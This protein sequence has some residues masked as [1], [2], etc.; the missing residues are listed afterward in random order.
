MQRRSEFAILC[1]NPPFYD[2]KRFSQKGFPHGGIS[3][4]F[5][6][7]LFTIIFKPKM[8][9]LDTYSIL[10]GQTMVEFLIYCVLSP[11]HIVSCW[12]DGSKVTPNNL[13][14]F[15][16]FIL[17]EPHLR[18]PL[19][20]VQTILLMF[21]FVLTEPHCLSKRCMH[22][23]KLC[24]G[25]WTKFRPM[26]SVCCGCLPACPPLSPLNMVWALSLT[27]VRTHSCDIACSLQALSL[28]ILHI[29]AFC[30]DLIQCL[31]IS[32]SNQSYISQ[33]P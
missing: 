14:D 30:K 22:G 23:L 33:V 4:Y 9:S 25:F 12:V 17:T 13:I 16:L 8:L 28:H 6:R 10:T 32:Y 31:H 18:R 27:C 5:Y 3:K 21:F 2:E 24:Q 1:K 15:F 11:L 20:K 19:K 7:P 29:G 26:P